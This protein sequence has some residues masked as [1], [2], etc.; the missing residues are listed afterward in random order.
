M[1][2]VLMPLVGID[3]M[4]IGIPNT[5]ARPDHD[6]TADRDLHPRGDRCAR[7]GSVFPMVMALSGVSAARIV[8]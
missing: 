5:G 4:E 6:V 1:R 7:N 2:R 3:G 8:G